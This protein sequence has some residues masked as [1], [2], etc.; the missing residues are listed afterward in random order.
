MFLILIFSWNAYSQIGIKDEFIVN[1][2]DSI[3]NYY[4][5]YVSTTKEVTF[6]GK[7]QIVSQKQ[8]MCNCETIKIGGKYKM[9][10]ERVIDRYKKIGINYVPSLT[11]DEKMPDGSIINFETEWGSD[12]CSTENIFGLCY[13]K[14][15]VGDSNA[16]D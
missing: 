7:Y 12:L 6:P 15:A 10:L 4:L 5:I 8:P 16:S 13:I 2:I 3:G 14:L 1:H 9:L 11:I